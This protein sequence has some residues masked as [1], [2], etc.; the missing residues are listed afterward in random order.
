V[1][2]H[3]PRLF[4]G[5][6][7]SHLRL[8]Y[9]ACNLSSARVINVTNAGWSMDEKQIDDTILKEIYRINGLQKELANLESLWK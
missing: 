3:H 4:T 2:Q 7:E 9:N 5:A 8:Y 1:N 6:A